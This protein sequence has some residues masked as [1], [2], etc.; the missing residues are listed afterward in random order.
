MVHRIHNSDKKLIVQKFG[1]TS[2]SSIK[3]LK[4]VTLIVKK[5]IALGNQV[6]VVV[7]AMGDFTD[8]LCDY[9]SH[10][11]VTGHHLAEKD[12]VL[13]TG[14][15]ITS[16]LLALAL[17]SS[18]TEAKSLL[19]WQV[20]IYTDNTHTKSS[21]TKIRTQNIRACLSNNVVPIIA[22]F[23]GI[24]IDNG[25]IT[26]LGRG[27]SDITAVEIAINLNA[28]R[29]DIYTDVDGIYTADP[30]L[31]PRAGKLA[32]VTYEEMLE[33]SATGANVLHVYAVES[34]MCNKIKLQILSSFTNT[35]GTSL[36]ENKNI[37]TNKTVTAITCKNDE[38]C[39]TIHQ[40][41][42]PTII[43][44]HLAAADINVNIIVK[45]LNSDDITFTVPKS[46]TQ[47]SIDILKQHKMTIDTHISI[48]SA[49]GIGM[50]LNPGIAC[51]MFEELKK[52]NIKILAITTSEIK[53]S[54]I[55]DEK[56]TK[57]VT[58]ILHTAY[59]LDVAV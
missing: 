22:G 18:Q 4:N 3:D 23:Q 9:V 56:H 7:S 5:E 36:L 21:I 17:T 1:G 25:K 40:I 16:G 34:A 38:N 2:L 50:M 29:C 10:F 11:H 26:T 57:L 19:G 24:N 42:N 43:F 55:I 30:N 54:I 58:K 33:M 8:T 14:E 44:T 31:V 28:D 15:Q 45:T 12:T 47:E 51:T 32:E 49:I 41:D 13:S 37:M 46:D 6:I 39:I 53:I 59:G 48:I 27:G 52:N 20:P 35:K